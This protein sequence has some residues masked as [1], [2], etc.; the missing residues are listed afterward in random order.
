MAVSKSKVKLKHGDITKYL[1]SINTIKVKTGNNT[2]KRI[3]IL[4]SNHGVLWDKHYYTIQSTS[5]SGY[6]TSQTTGE[7]KTTTYKCAECGKTKTETS[8]WRH[9]MRDY[10]F[11]ATFSTNKYGYSECTRC[12]LIENYYVEQNTGGNATFIFQTSGSGSSLKRIILTDL[13]IEAQYLI[14]SGTNYILQHSSCNNQTQCTINYVFMIESTSSTIKI[15]MNNGSWEKLDTQKIS[16]SPTLYVGAY[17][18][19][20]DIYPLEAFTFTIAFV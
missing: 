3:C 14:S 13:D 11:D 18:F 12:H 8:S 19:S 16:S 2:E 1:S 20:G 17:P 7:S 15:K 6:C 9:N 10:D 4:N 5:G